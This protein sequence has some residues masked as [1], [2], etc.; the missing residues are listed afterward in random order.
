MSLGELADAPGAVRAGRRARRRRRARSRR[1]ARTARAAQAS[2]SFGTL[3]LVHAARCSAVREAPEARP[4]PA[5]REPSASP[6]P[7]RPVEGLRWPARA[8]RSPGTGAA[9]HRPACGAAA[10][11]GRSWRGAAHPAP[12]GSRPR[13][14]T[15]APA[16]APRR[17]G[18]SGA[19]P[20]LLQQREQRAGGAARRR[21]RQQRQQRARRRVD[22]A[23]RAAADGVGHAALARR[24][25]ED[26]VDQRRGGVQVGR[27]DQDV[28]GLQARAARRTGRAGGPAAP[29]ARASANGT[30]AARC[31]GR[32]SARR[33]R[34]GRELVQLEDRVLHAAPAGCRPAPARSGRRPRRLRRTARPATPHAPASAG[35]RRRAGGCLLH[36]PAPGRAPPGGSRRRRSISSNQYSRQ[37]LST[38][39]CTST[40]AP[41]CCSSRMCSGGHARQREDMHARRQPGAARQRRCRRAAARRRRPAPGAARACPARRRCAAT[42][43]PARPRRGDRLSPSV[44]AAALAP[45]PQPV[46][47]VGDVLLQQGRRRGRPARSASRR[48]R[49]AGRRPA[50]RGG[51]R[52]RHR[53]RRR[54]RA[55]RAASR[56]KAR[57]R[58]TPGTSRAICCHSH[59]GEK[60]EVH[61]GADALRIGDGQAQR[62]AA[63]RRSAR[64]PARR[65][66]RP[67]AL[68]PRRCSSSSR[69][70]S[71]R[72]EK[73]MC[74]MAG[75]TGQSMRH[76]AGPKARQTSL[77]PA[78]VHTTLR[79]RHLSNTRREQHHPHCNDPGRTHA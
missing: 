5:A 15:R 75:R 31:C 32:A 56:R 45:G 18:R 63:A 44:G 2:G 21:Q 79:S 30:H 37:G 55:R 41:S 19:R 54:T 11:A 16:P 66:T 72:L 27:H 7:S 34:A 9:A 76:A 23:A 74:S 39:R 1:A 65:R 67:R 28:A 35:P 20:R 13:A 53:R 29:R 14:A 42:A 71:S 62:G 38:Y 58:P 40:H 61:V 10:P 33:H 17:P 48:R 25:A 49:R 8:A 22:A 3:Q 4:A 73:W 6:A 51:P 59:C 64:S 43:R 78:M 24:G 36:A 47:A 12:S 69:S 68:A 26:R 50:A 57:L 52:S 77:C 60:G 70:G 46:G